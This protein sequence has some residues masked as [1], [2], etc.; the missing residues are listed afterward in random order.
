[1]KK[2]LL[3]LVFLVFTVLNN[4]SAQKSTPSPDSLFNAPD[5]VCINQPVKLTSNVFN[6]VNYYWGFCSGYLMNAPT[7]LN[8]GRSFK[9][10]NPTGIDIAFDSGNYYGFVIN[11]GDRNGRTLLRLNY[12]T[13]LNN[14]PTVTNFGDLTKGLP[15]NPTSLYLVKDTFAH[16]WHLFVS[17]GFTSATS[18]MA[19]IDFGAHLSNPRPNI[20][21]FG[22]YNGLLNYPKGIFI[23]QDST[24][25]W[26]GYVVNHNNSELIRLDFSFNVSNTPLMASMGVVADPG[27]NPIISFPTDMAAIKDNKQWYLFVTNKG[28]NSIARIDLGKSLSPAPLAIT[29]ANLGNFL[30][31]ID[32][33]SS[34]TLN[35]D[36]GDLYAYVTD[37]TTSQLVGIQMASAVGP[38]NA[39]S[40][41]V[42]GG[43]DFP[44]GIS[45]ILRDKDNLYGFICNAGDSTLTRINF[46]QCTNSSIPSYTEVNPPVYSYDAPGI[47]NIYYVINQGQ[48]NM[49]VDC[50]PITVIANPPVYISND[51]TLCQGDTLKLYAISSL[52]DSI[53]W[54]TTYNIDTSYLYRDSARV[55][56]NYSTNYAVRLYYPFGCV[57]DTNVQVNVSKVV[58]D[59]GPDRWV[60]DGATTTL[61][62]PYTSMFDSTWD[63]HYAYHWEPYQFLSDT[64]GPNPVA[65]PPYDFT[66]YLTV[67]E[68]NDTFKCSR[69]DTVTVRMKCDDIY[70]PNVFA[71]NS[72]NYATSHFGIINQQIAKLNYLRIYDR[73]GALVFETTDVTQSWDGNFNN[74]PCPVG[75]YVWIADA[76]CSSGKRISK[77][78]NVTIMR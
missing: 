65:S 12:G 30:F 11:K 17:G 45:S 39:V 7:G 61:G 77:S 33:P 29:G 31:R 26:Y 62:G 71:P 50:K 16:H 72:E 54:I 56:P 73:W 55:A 48:P 46:V 60:K 64:L 47:Y 23:A 43:M 27:G 32:S 25:V 20:V 4:A 76:F 51:T 6:R 5:T 38:Y 15:V 58:A 34:I 2:H 28:D 78:G 66:Y 18:T 14:I 52:A 24:N 13:S 40:Y 37:S 8:L 19:R 35:R 68:M 74:K 63:R 69:K 44:S 10:D 75:V 59:A 36:C 41:S 1:M 53:R 3:F 49:Q 42:L 21:N 70:L 57:V 67:T 9:F 22:N